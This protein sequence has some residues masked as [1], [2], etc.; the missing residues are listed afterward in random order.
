M[1]GIKKILL[2]VAEEELTKLKKW[3]KLNKQTWEEFVLGFRLRMMTIA[4]NNLEDKEKM[5][6]ELCNLVMEE[7][8]SLINGGGLG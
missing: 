4:E 2:T 5:A 8:N 3:K 1:I 6:E 7:I